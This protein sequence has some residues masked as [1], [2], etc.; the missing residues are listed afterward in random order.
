MPESSYRPPA[1]QSSSGGYSGHPGSSSAYLSTMPESSYRPP[2]IYGSSSEYSDQQ[3]QA[4]GQQSMAPRAPVAQPPRGGGQ[5]GRGHPRGRVQIGRSQPATAQSGGGQSADAPARFYAI[6]ARPDV[7]PL[8]VVI[9]G[10]IF[11]YG[12]DASL[13]F[14]PGST[15]SYVL[16]LFAHF[17]DITREPLGTLV[18]VSTHVGD[19]VV[20]DRIYRSC[21]VTFCGFETRADL[22]LLDMTHFEVILVMD[23]LSL[24]HAV[25]DCHAKTVTLAMLELP[26]LEWK[27]SSVNISS[28]VIYLLKAR[29][30]VEKGCLAYLAYVRD[31]T[32]ESSTIDSVLIVREFAD[33]F[34]FDLPG[35]P[36]DRNID[37]CIDLDPGT[38]PISIPPYHMDPKELKDLKEQLEELLAKQ[39][40]RPS[41]SPWG[42]LVL[43]VKKKDG[44]MRMCIDYHQLNKDTI[45]N[46]YLL[47]CIDDFF[48]HLQGAR[49][50]SKINL[51]SGYHQLKIQDSD[52]PNSA[53]RTRYGHYEFL[54]KARQIDDLYLAVL[55]E[56]VLQGSAKEVSI[57][58]DGVLRL[59]GRVCV[60]N[61]NG[62]RERIL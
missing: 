34:P 22:M 42:A 30:M 6:P 45:K 20:V 18:H 5:I 4:S 37:F 2:A 9:I 32:V 40:V 54:I 23:L 43:F 1:I 24:Y 44:T 10:I 38:Q 12:R 46:M 52:V 7:L 35:M 16:S 11:V 36:L 17:L 39:F 8:D 31:T 51:R 61:V 25:L 56:T 58:E 15:Y 21:V 49:V 50:F 28:R 55:K 57:G 29:H 19:S 14:D 59:Q 3:T 47:S 60:P 41:V 27:G 62:L 53:F 13:L 26:R 33:V 48:T